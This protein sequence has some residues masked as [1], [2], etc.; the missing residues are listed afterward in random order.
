MDPK[1]ASTDK[2]RLAIRLMQKLDGDKKLTDKIA[3]KLTTSFGKVTFLAGNFLFFFLWIYA[4]THGIA[5]LPVFD[6]YP[7]GLL[8]MLVSLEAIF[9]STVVLISQNRESTLARMRMELDLIITIEAEEETTRIL[10]MLDEIHDHL[11]LDPHDDAEL[12]E[13]KEEVD[14]S[15]LRTL[16]LSKH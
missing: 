4:N 3:D 16:L 13:M 2:E 15:R 6:P 12:T 9:L 5:G 7:F 11:G 1:L 10:K 8:T 14:I